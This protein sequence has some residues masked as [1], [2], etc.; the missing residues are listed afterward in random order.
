MASTITPTTLRVAIVEQI[1][2]NGTDY[3]ART[4][5]SFSSISEVSK[6]IITTNGTGSTTIIRFQPSASAGQFINTDIRYLRITNLDNANYATLRFIGSGSTDYAFRLDPT[7]S[8]IMSLTQP[9]S[10]ANAGVTSYADIAGVTL[11]D[12]STISAI[13]NSASVDLELFVASI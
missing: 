9:S 6:R 1:S 4:I 10:S 12:L 2:L 3:G 7:G 5:A 11:T 8:H 13:A